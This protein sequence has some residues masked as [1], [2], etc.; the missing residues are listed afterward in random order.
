[1]T[2]PYLGEIRMFA[3]NFAPQGW[4]FCDGQL[5][6]V[7][8]NQA[9]FSLLGTTY[10]GDGRQSFGLPDLRGRLPLH[11]GQGP[12]LSDYRLGQRG[13]AESVALS[14][15]EMP[16]HS[17]TAQ[18]QVHVSSQPGQVADPSGAF[19]ADSGTTNT[20]ATSSDSAT[21]NQGAV[22]VTNSNA[23]SGQPHTNMQPYACVN[24]I[25]ALVGEYPQRS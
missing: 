7:A 8:Q 20:Y 14:D 17:H 2:N 18:V 11:P 13:G 25:I 15:A 23:G 19:L 5:L 22:Q 1:M 21:L 16:A 6:S 10:G 4:A 3:G 12:G 9:L 24:F